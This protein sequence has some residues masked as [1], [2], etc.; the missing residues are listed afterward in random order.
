M[1]PFVSGFSARPVCLGVAF[2]AAALSLPVRGAEP[3]S[4]ARLPL[5]PIAPLLSG[6]DGKAE[7]Q[8]KNGDAKNGDN[9]GDKDKADEVGPELSLGECTAIAL[10][11]SPALR[12]ALMSERATGLSSRALNNI[13]SVG[14]VFAPDLPIRKEQASR[15][16]IAAAADVQKKRSEIVQDV[17]RLYYTVVYARQQEA[18][19]DDVVA[20]LEQLVKIAADLLETPQPGTLT[21]PLLYT[22]ELGLGDARTLQL[23]AKTGRLQAMAALEEVM[24][25]CE[26]EFPFRV[27]DRELPVIGAKA[28]LTKEMVVDAALACRPEM[29]LAAAGVDAFRLEVYAQ[30]RVPCRQSVRTFASGSDIHARQVPQGSR[31]ATYRPEAIAPEMP[32]QLV[33]SKLDRVARAGAY[34]ERA[35]AVYEKTRNLVALEAKAAFFDLDK[36]ARGVEVGK[37]KFDRGKKLYDSVRDNIDNPKFP[38]EQLV[39]QYAA[40]AKAQS[41]YV[42]AVYQ[43]LLALAALERITGGAIRPPFPGR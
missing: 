7:P 35:E 5:I 19:A 3:E 21:R 22:M 1:Q 42:E 34:C 17:T 4:P 10:E 37:V 33:G 29:A 27:K 32:P 25:V 16:L 20:L 31:D 9:N 2:L 30:A 41:D 8:K 43:H 13:G 28:R 6:Q 11:R 24:S 15:G 14:A 36:A 12:A 23:R 38:R 18:I 26:G 40:G 39:A